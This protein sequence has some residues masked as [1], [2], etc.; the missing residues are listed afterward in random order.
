MK[1]NKIAVYAGT[2]NIYQD[3]VPA[4]KSLLIHSDVDKIYFLI[5]DDEFPYPLSS[6]IECINVSHQA[7]FRADGPNF[8]SSWTYMVLMRAALSKLF[9]QDDTILSLDVDT[10]VNENISTLWNVNIDDYYLAAVKEEHKSTDDFLYINMGVVL[11]NLKKLREDYKDDEII[12]AL[13]T[14]Y[15]EYNEQ[16]CINEL[17]QGYIYR[18]PAD[19]NIN[20]WTIG[21][22]HRKIIHYA[23][24]KKWQEMPLVKHYASYNWRD[25]PYNWPDNF[26]LDII[27]PTYKNKK[28]LDL[29]LQS[30]YSDE[31]F[32]LGYQY[33]FPVRITVVDDCSDLD[34][35]DLEKKYRLV[36]FIYKKTNEGPGMA[37]QT[38]LDNT[39]LPY[40][41]F[42]DTGDY[43]LSKYAILQI[44]LTILSNTVP[45]IYLWRWL[46]E[47]NHQYSDNGSPLLHGA[48][49]K[50][51][52]LKLYNIRFCRESS[53][54]NEDVGFNRAC[55]LVIRQLDE[56]D[57]TLKL[58]FFHTPIY[59]YTL[60]KNSITHANN[61]EF[62]YTKQ[63]DGL[64]KN[65]YHVVKIAEENKISPN[66]IWEEVSF[67]M[68]RLYYDFWIVMKNRPELGQA[69]WILLR[70]YYQDLFKKYQTSDTTV[71]SAA[72]GQFSKSLMKLGIKQINFERF[73]RELESEEYVPGQ[74]FDF[75]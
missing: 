63:L 70:R 58:Q 25:I 59:M 16:D 61:K 24:V 36:K 42:I 31:I 72:K 35:S 29:T 73:L 66:Y 55:H 51:E 47:E 74:Y 33:H 10:I 34:Y 13:N 23:A 57:S 7:Y 19:Y 67:I 3:M 60:D 12:E 64:V 5:E 38:A 46:N 27:I 56:Y 37:R 48:V 32:M 6:K 75:C 11:F 1:Q 65:I 62:L 21:A 28:A 45:Y 49:Y 30:V 14:K 17:C 18:L 41:M 53:Y 39:C 69:A 20:N 4:A 9:P 22:K 40:V 54:S 68:V 71:I 43:I 26:G 8:S 2:R 44:M 52:F 15:Y 50:R